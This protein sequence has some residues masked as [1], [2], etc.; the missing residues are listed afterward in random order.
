MSASMG[1]IAPFYTQGMPN[2]NGNTRTFTGGNWTFNKTAETGRTASTEVNEFLLDLDA[3]QQWAT[4]ALTTQRTTLIK[5]QTLSF[6]GAS[7]VTN[8]ATLAI[9]AAP[10]AGT[11]ATITN[12]YALWVQAGKTKL[13]GGVEILQAASASTSETIARIG[14]SDVAIAS[15]HFDFVNNTTTDAAFTALFRMTATGTLGNTMRFAGT[16]DTGSTAI[17]FIDSRIGA[18]TSPTTRP[19]IQFLRGGGIYCSFDAYGRLSLT[20]AVS[21]SGLDGGFSL[22]PA[23]STGV[24]ASTESPSFQ[25]VTHTKTWA[26]GALTTQREYL[27]AAPTYAFAGASTI[28]SAATLAITGAP[29]AGTNAT[30]TNAYALW[31]QAG[32]A[33]V[34][35]DPTLVNEGN[36]LVGCRGSL[37]A[38]SGNLVANIIEQV[39]T[40]A[41][42]SSAVASAILANS[43]S[44]G[45]QN[46]TATVGLIGVRARTGHAT[47]GTCTGSAAFYADVNANTGGGTLTNAY[48]L[49]CTARGAGTNRWGVYVD[50]D[51]SYFG[52][53]LLVGTTAIGA[54]AAG[55]VLA[56]GN[57]ATAPSDS[58]DLAQLYAVDL[59]AG[60]CTLGIRVETAV[61]TEAVAS[62][63]TL[64]VKINGTNYKILLAA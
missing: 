10:I 6:V 27:F 5:A 33:L 39:T 14:I 30:I 54:S 60:N 37:N 4:G 13:D 34:G 36:W 64:T 45:A 42:S 25:V 2:T 62:D 7:T 57:G 15:G 43:A 63:R 49:Y 28:T 11:N 1:N 24:T 29:I 22:T 35:S 40:P 23:A 32:A 12:A 48:G 58:A 19:C 21:T 59:S 3:T 41:A 55:G 44:S 26:T 47:S 9:D 31:V 51:Q 16:T 61:V 18:S 52:G 20:P 38:T 53:N 56:L 50:T 8:A 17:G 46:L